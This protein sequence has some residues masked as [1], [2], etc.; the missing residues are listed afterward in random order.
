MERGKE[1]IIWRREIFG[2][3]RRRRTQKEKE[4]NIW[5][6]EDKKNGEGKGGNYLE[7]GNI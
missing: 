7:K 6:T 1:E 3:R 2:Q 4:E 5:L